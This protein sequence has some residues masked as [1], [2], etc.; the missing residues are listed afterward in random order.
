[1]IFVFFSGKLAHVLIGRL[2]T[3]VVFWGVNCFVTGIK[4]KEIDS[5]LIEY[6]LGGNC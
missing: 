6:F 1:M 2:S 5:Y 3:G 4:E